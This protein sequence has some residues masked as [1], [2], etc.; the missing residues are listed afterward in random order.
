MMDGGRKLWSI[1]TLESISCQKIMSAWGKI[2]TTG[3]YWQ[4]REGHSFW[5]VGPWAAGCQTYWAV[6]HQR[7]NS[8][9]S[10]TIKVHTFLETNAKWR[11]FASGPILPPIRWSCNGSCNGLPSEVMSSK[12]V[13][14]HPR[15][16][17]VKTS[18]FSTSFPFTAMWCLIIG[19]ITMS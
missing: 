9:A 4:Q 6:D 12:R 1:H 17:S 11:P 16:T 3:V 5:N 15:K 8:A 18:P 10:F 7:Q 13:S 14:D 19:R 2:P